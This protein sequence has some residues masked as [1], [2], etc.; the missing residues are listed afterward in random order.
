MQVVDEKDLTVHGLG[1][2]LHRAIVIH[3]QL[4]HL[5]IW[6]AAFFVDDVIG[7]EGGFTVSS[8]EMSRTAR[9]TVEALR[10]SSWRA[11]SKSILRW[12]Q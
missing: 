7:K 8:L 12:L 5:H 3:F 11:F 9:I 1:E 2:E 4:H 10:V 6:A